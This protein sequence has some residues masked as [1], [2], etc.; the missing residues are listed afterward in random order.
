MILI[1][2]FFHTTIV[3]SV[4][5]CTFLSVFVTDEC[6]QEFIHLEH[7]LMP[8]AMD[9]GNGWVLAPSFP[10][11]S[12]SFFSMWDWNI[13]STQSFVFENK[14]K[15]AEGIVLQCFCNFPII[16][17]HWMKQ[18]KRYMIG[19]IPNLH[20]LCNI[21]WSAGELRAKPSDTSCQAHTL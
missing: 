2:L 8:L 9:L 1:C 10:R 17:S 16:L 5:I 15:L 18:W 13:V 4:L 12:Q 6:I 20:P 3:S 7:G 19:F 21:M 14:S 11:T